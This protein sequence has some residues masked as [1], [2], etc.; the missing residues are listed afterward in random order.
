MRKEEKLS[1]ADNVDIHYADDDQEDI[2][3]FADAVAIIVK[4]GGEK[5]TLKVYGDG[6]SLLNAINTVLL[7]NSIIFLDINMPGKNGVDVLRE[8]RSKDEF[9][10]IPIVMFSTSSQ[11]ESIVAS[12]EN[13]ASLYVIKPENFTSLI[14][15]IEKII[16]LKWSETKPDLE[17]FVFGKKH[18]Y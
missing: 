17:N 11:K 3:L 4:K 6:D 2:E 14:E 1:I 9:K 10:N 8:L 12:W 16:D 15:T 13:G 18:T 7:N 5:I